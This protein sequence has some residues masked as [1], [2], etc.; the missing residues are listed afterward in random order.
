M[1]M[2]LVRSEMWIRDGLG[3]YY[4]RGAVNWVRF[5]SGRWKA[6]ASRPRAGDR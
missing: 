2:S 5:R 6:V 4:A 1:Q 3:D